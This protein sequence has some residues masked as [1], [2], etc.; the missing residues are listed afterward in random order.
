M[1]RQ[2]LSFIDFQIKIYCVICILSGFA[3]FRGFFQVEDHMVAAQLHY[4]AAASERRNDSE[5][6]REKAILAFNE[7]R[8][9]VEID[10]QQQ[11]KKS[12]RQ[13]NLRVGLSNRL[14]KAIGDV[15]YIRLAIITVLK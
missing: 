1:S 12:I 2:P 10:T 14:R 11:Y 6:F 3:I 8:A 5:W 9:S 4:S 7:V 15:H 13:S